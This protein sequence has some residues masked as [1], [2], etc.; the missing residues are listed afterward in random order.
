MNDLQDIIAAYKQRLPLLERTAVEIR[1]LLNELV[2]K[3]ARVDLVSVRVKSAESFASKARR[4]ADH[5]SELRYTRPLDEIQDQIGAR[6]AVYYKSDV[7]NVADAL[8]ARLQEVP[9]HTAQLAPNPTYFGYEV[10]H[11]NCQIPEPILQSLHPPVGCFE[12]Q[13]GTLF[14]HAWAQC[15]HD[16]GYKAAGAVSFEDRRKMAWAAAQAWGADEIFDEM[17]HKSRPDPARSS[18]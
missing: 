10:R 4:T 16:L 17:W 5:S 7:Q 3:L 9:D 13:I 11:F 15:E 14:Q 8:L 12:L 2:S 1:Q 6:I 18:G